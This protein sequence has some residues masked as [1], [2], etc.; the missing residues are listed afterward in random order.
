M[1]VPLFDLINIFRKCEDVP[2]LIG[3]HKLAFSHLDQ[4]FPVK[5]GRVLCLVA[6]SKQ[7]NQIFL[8]TNRYFMFLKQKRYRE[9]LLLHIGT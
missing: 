5:Q 8:S 7:G 2:M 6:L 9:H 1:H 4:L 3:T